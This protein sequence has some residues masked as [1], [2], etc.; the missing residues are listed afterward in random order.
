MNQLFPVL[1]GS[2]TEVLPTANGTFQTAFMGENT[3]QNCQVYIEFF[4]DEAGTIPATPSAGTIT[5]Q[6]RPMEN[7]W[8]AA[9]SGGSINA[10]ACATPVSTYTP[11]YFT[12]RMQYGRIT[13]ASIAGAA[14]ARVT[15]WRY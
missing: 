13:F 5:V 1:N 8:V 11:S 15:F 6:G 7:N 2:G 10:S 12:G 9:S 4:S 14:F 3:S